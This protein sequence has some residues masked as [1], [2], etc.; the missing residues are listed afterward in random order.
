MNNLD[1]G[2]HPFHLVRLHS[3]PQYQFSTNG[4]NTQ[5]GHHFYVLIVHKASIGW[6][7]YNPFRDEFPPGLVSHSEGLSDLNPDT[8]YNISRAVLRDTVQIPS[9]GYAVLRF[10]AD[11]PGVWMFHCHILWH[12]A[13]GMAMLVDV[14]R[15]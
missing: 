12:L 1:E 15:G 13:S 2:A 11:N 6:G 3:L 8:P 9:R 7:S 10:R 14:M 4:V 5:H